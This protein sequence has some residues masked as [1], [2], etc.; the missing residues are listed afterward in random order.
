MIEEYAWTLNAFI[1][2]WWDC[3][4]LPDDV[5]PCDEA[6]FRLQIRELAFTVHPLHMSG[7]CTRQVYESMISL[8]NLSVAYD[9]LAE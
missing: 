6:A 9:G 3:V 7:C 5:D 8:I 4:A 2:R 1:Y